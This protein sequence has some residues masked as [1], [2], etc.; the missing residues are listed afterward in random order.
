MKY[1]S[2]TNEFSAKMKSFRLL[3]STFG[4]QLLGRVTAVDPSAGYANVFCADGRNLFLCTEIQGNTSR[5]AVID[6][7]AL[8][9]VR[10]GDV[11]EAVAGSR[12]T[13][14][15]SPRSNDCSLFVTEECNSRCLSCP[16]PPRKNSRDWPKLMKQVLALIDRPPVAF[17]ITGGEPSLCFQELMDIVAIVRHRFPT[18]PVEVL[19]N[20]T[21]FSDTDHV[22][23]MASLSAGMVSFHV[24]LFSDSESLHNEM[25]GGPAYYRT[26]QGLRQLIN[27]GMPVEIRTVVTRMTFNRLPQLANFVCRY[28]PETF[29][30][31]IMELEP[32]G[33]ALANLQRLRVD[34]M[35]SA[36]A[37]QAAVRIC[38]LHG[39]CCALYNR[40]LCMLTH[41]L[42]PCATK[43]ISDW[44]N[45]YLTGK[46]RI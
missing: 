46:R 28:F 36:E 23:Q 24:T 31:A 12:L 32:A 30:F 3:Q 17:G 14:L 39:L 34:P 2:K 8:V 19:T 22:A 4:G 16:Q 20:A 21:G 45:V 5:Q 11:I 41:D 6:A 43:S 27:A 15:L 33:L 38:Q 9:L 13:L 7:T 44:K 40:P 26:L 42:W 25:A 18:T 1:R 29:R 10:V 37:L 35:D